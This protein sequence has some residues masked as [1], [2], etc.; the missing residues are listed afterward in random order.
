MNISSNCITLIKHHEGVRNTPYQDPIGLWTVGVGHLM[1]N[2]KR[3]PKDW[4]RKRSDQEVDDLLRYDIRRFE[5]GVE[6][7]INV[8]L[9]QNQFDALVCFAFNVGLGN[10]QASTLRRKLNRGDYEGA[11]NEF[12]KWRRAGG[13]VLNGL[14]KR[15]NDERLLFIK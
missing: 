2:G 9:N 11:S 6:R 7:M 5:N 1:G 14:V 10:L 12:P 3:R 15:R 13:R 4:N 8:S